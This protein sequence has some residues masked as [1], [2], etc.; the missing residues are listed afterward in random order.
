[1]KKALALSAFA[2]VMALPLVSSA[3]S[4]TS[5][6]L[7]STTGNAN[8]LHVSDTIQ[9]EVTITLDTHTYDTVF[10]QV[11]GDLAGLAIDQGGNGP[12]PNTDHIVTNWEWAYNSGNKVDMGT[13]GRFVP[14]PEQYPHPNPSSGPYGFFAQAG[15]TGDGTPS[16]VGTVTIHATAVGN[17]VGGAFVDPIFDGFVN[18]GVA[19]TP[20]VTGSAFT[21]VPEPGTAVL[22]L[23]GLGGLGVMGRRSR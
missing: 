9:F 16:L 18:L 17:Y 20:T 19:D 6:F 15:K 21:V 5:T 10:W 13:N 14:F 2:L 7:T 1:M 23:L 3:S 11:G 22:M 8:D 12:W 4:I